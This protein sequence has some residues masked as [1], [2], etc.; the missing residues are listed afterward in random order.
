[1][2]KKIKKVDKAFISQI[3]QLRTMCVLMVQSEVG[4]ATQVRVKP[5]P[6]WSSSRKD[7]SDWSMVPAVTLPAQDEHAPARQE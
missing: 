7:W 1:M 6:I 3:F 2:P 5:A 4:Y